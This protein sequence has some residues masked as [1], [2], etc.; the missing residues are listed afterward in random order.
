MLYIND[1]NYNKAQE[2]AERA[3][4]QSPDRPEI[5]DTYGWVLV[6]LDQAERGLELLQTA[7]AA[8]PDNPDVHYHVAAAQYASGNRGKAIQ[9]LES[10]LKKHK[11]FETRGE[12]EKLLS[13][14]Q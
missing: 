5:A 9:E 10:L 2:Y 4:K 8:I 3:Y 14:L 12:A 11:S 6:K 7:L 13:S 1:G